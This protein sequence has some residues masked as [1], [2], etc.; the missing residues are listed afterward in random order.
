MN[1]ILRNLLI[2]TAVLASPLLA[3]CGK[4]SP[5]RPT[6]AAPTAGPAT[7]LQT[8][9]TVKRILVIEDG[10]GVEG[11]GDFHFTA[12]VDLQRKDWDRTMGNGE[13]TTLNWSIV[14]HAQSGSFD[15]TFR[16]TEWDTN[17]L[18]QVYP[19]SDMDGREKSTSHSYAPSSDGNYS[20]ELGNSNCKVRMYY[21]IES[22]WVPVQP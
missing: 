13:S 20:I 14:L 3:G 9:V 1:P 16:A 2:V 18:G 22:E 4:S 19:D 15:V 11:K 6:A 5:T 8:T 21:T 7:T 17:V 10:D 12:F